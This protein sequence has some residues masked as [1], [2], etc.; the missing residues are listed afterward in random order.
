MKQALWT[1]L[2]LESPYFREFV[3]QDSFGNVLFPWGAVYDIETKILTSNH[4][5]GFGANLSSLLGPLIYLAGA[6]IFP[7]EL[8]TVDGFKNFREGTSSKPLAQLF[9]RTQLPIIHQD[10]A[11]LGEFV[12]YVNYFGKFR[13]ISFD[14]SL[15][16]VLNYYF[17]PLQTL[18][19]ETDQYFV[20][21]KIDPSFCLSV[22]IRGTDGVKGDVDAVC[23]FVRTH[24][25]RNRVSAVL[26]HTDDRSV[27]KRALLNMFD[28]PV[29]VCDLLPL[30]SPNFNQQ[31]LQPGLSPSEAGKLSLITLLIMAKSKFLVVGSGQFS[32]WAVLLRGNSRGVFQLVS[33]GQPENAFYVRLLYWF[34]KIM[35]PELVSF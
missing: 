17:S 22:F 19:D 23:T 27:A 25:Y 4:S 7:V 3:S 26:L 28:L 5:S 6:N 10:Q 30:K 24:C 32:L 9:T 14:R 8:S 2:K 16:T 13:N 21:K 31:H 12:Y 18:V 15:R 29:V 34:V 20:D 35:R 1:I 33:G 11:R